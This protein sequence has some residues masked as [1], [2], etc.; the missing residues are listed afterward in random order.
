MKVSVRAVLL[1]AFARACWRMAS[2]L[3]RLGN[4]AFL[5]TLRAPRPSRFRE[6][7]SLFKRGGKA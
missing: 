5:E 1:I 3:E 4:R 7:A 6:K 2:R